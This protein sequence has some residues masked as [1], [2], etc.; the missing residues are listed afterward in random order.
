MNRGSVNG[1]DAS[2]Y[3]G[4][5]GAHGLSGMMT[6]GSNILLPSTGEI[7]GRYSVVICGGKVLEKVLEY[8][9]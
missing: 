9:P 5:A 4:G 1:G 7:P 3:G 6:G 2:R 8:C